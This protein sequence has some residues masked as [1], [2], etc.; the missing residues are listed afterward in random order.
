MSKKFKN[1]NSKQ[2]IKNILFLSLWLGLYFYLSQQYYR[3]KIETLYIDEDN[4]IYIFVRGLGHK[5][6]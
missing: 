2:F 5:N 3:W 6:Y 4:L 1:L